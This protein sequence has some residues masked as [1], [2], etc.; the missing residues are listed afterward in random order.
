MRRLTLALAFL[1]AMALAA[2]TTSPP[3]QP[4]DFDR[5]IEPI[6]K[7]KCQPCHFPG[8]KMYEKRPF[9]KPETIVALGEKLFTRIHDE[10]ERALIRAFL[11]E[12]KR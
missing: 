10:K 2:S 7:A 8:G 1:L 6:L 12:Q 11:A 4:V 9:D 5:E 3:K